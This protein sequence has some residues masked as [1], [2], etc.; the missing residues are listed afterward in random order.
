MNA[1]VIYGSRSGNTRKI[2]RAIARA[3]EG[4][5]TVRLEA[6]DEAPST[7]G[8]I[9]LVVVGGP[10]EAHGITPPV[11]GFFDRMAAGALQ[12]RKAAAFDTRLR[13]PR[14][15]WGSAGAGITQKLLEAGAEVIVPEE[16]FFVDRV[17]RLLPGE[18]D[19]AAAWGASL[20]GMLE[21]AAAASAAAP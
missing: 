21:P 16:S 8:G 17:P 20:V 3:L 19:R 9:D 15:L 5:G 14:W 2:G 4:H 1:V 6:I 12:G 7:F 11:A 10:T 13:G 18:L